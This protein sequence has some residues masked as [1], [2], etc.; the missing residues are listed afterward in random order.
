MGK[1]MMM[2]V[3]SLFVFPQ[4]ALLRGKEEEKEKKSN[5]N[6]MNKKRPRNRTQ[7]RRLS[8]TNQKVFMLLFWVLFSSLSLCL[9]V[10]V[11]LCLSVC[12]SVCL[13]LSLSLS[14]SAV[15]LCLWALQFHPFT[16]SVLV[17]CVSVFFSHIFVVVDGKFG[18]VD[19]TL[20]S[21]AQHDLPDL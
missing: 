6:R 17:V 16:S 2:W 18:T 14:L 19:G 4:R 21:N 1:L 12:L 20:K 3:C 8:S 13:S 5:R 15:V 11:S 9:S 10:S 7:R